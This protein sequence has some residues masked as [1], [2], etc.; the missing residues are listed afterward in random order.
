M[1]G[2]ERQVAGATEEA[3]AAVVTEADA[4]WTDAPVGTRVVTAK[5]P[6]TALSA[7]MAARLEYTLSLAHLPA[8]AHGTVRARNRGRSEARPAARRGAR[9]SSGQDPGDSDP[10]PARPGDLGPAPHQPAASVHERSREPQW[11]MQLPWPDPVGLFGTGW[12]R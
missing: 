8:R 3:D 9:R 2:S 4:D 7:R 5:T 6:R 11:A 1:P 10:E 12:L